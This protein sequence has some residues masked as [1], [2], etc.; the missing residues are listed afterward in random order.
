MS[1]WCI[2][3]ERVPF[4]VR[5]LGSVPI[6]YVIHRILDHEFFGPVDPSAVSSLDRLW[7]LDILVFFFANA[8]SK[9]LFLY[10]SNIYLFIIY[11]I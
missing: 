2:S 11:F 10:N 1:H 6:V 4:Q 5:V 3:P 9:N 7:V 8:V